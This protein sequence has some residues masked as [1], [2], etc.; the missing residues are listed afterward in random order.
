M[1]ASAYFNGPYKN[2]WGRKKNFTIAISANWSGMQL[3]PQPSS[4]FIKKHILISRHLNEQYHITKQSTQPPALSHMAPGHTET[5]RSQETVGLL[6]PSLCCRKTACGAKKCLTH[7]TPS[8]QTCAQKQRHMLVLKRTCT[9]E[10][11]HSPPPT[12]PH[13]TMAHFA[14]HLIWSKA[15]PVHLLSPIR[16]LSN[17]SCYLVAS[18]WDAELNLFRKAKFG[19]NKVAALG[20]GLKS[21]TGGVTY[22]EVSQYTGETKFYLLS[23]EGILA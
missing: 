19:L 5:P 2:N 12:P 18:R 23:S 7:S 8:A 1:L 11:A 21:F 13:P 20:F 9:H 3:F 10:H 6:Q 16:W 4:L 17:K 15:F 22:I 14:S